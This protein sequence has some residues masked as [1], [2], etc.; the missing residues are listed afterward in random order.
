MSDK[1]VLIPLQLINQTLEFLSY[2]DVSKYDFSIR[3]DYDNIVDTFREKL[4]SLDLRE[5]YVKIITAKTEDE[6]DN[7]RIEYLRN[8]NSLF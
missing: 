6:R 4:R 5:S 3:C 2:I 7:A 1:K 8:K